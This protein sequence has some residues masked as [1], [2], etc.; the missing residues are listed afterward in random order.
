[1]KE[2]RKTMMKVRL[3]IYRMIDQAATDP[4]ARYNPSFGAGISGATAQTQ[5]DLLSRD[6]DETFVRMDTSNSVI[7]GLAVFNSEN[8]SKISGNQLSRLL[9]SSVK[10]I[11]TRKHS[12]NMNKII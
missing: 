2:M 9:F 5:G 7:G 3:I 12:V 8:N 11:E 6:G 4:V 10:G 1:M